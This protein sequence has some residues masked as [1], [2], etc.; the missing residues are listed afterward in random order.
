MLYADIGDC[1]ELVLGIYHTGGVRGVIEHEA[2]GFIGDGCLKLL[3]SDFKILLL[4]CFDYNRCTADHTY[5]F[6]IADPERS[7]NYDLITG[8]GNR[9]EGNVDTVLCAAGNDYLRVIIVNSAVLFK[10]LSYGLSQRNYACCRSVLCLTVANGLD[11]GHINVVRSIKIR[12]ARAKAHNVKSVSFHL[13][14]K[15]VYRE[16]SRCPNCFCNFRYWFHC[17]SPP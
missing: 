2:L 11:T 8:I 14:C 6:I 9:R 12:F 15:A 1:T 5:H 7:G 4:T 17:K 3:G 16:S 10:S 13:L